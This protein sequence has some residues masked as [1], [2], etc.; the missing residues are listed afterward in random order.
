MRQKKIQLRVLGVFQSW[1]WILW[2]EAK[3]EL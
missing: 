1:I 3:S 2:L